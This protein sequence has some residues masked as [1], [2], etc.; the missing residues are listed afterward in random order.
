V[1]CAPVA[2]QTK[3]QDEGKVLKKQTDTVVQEGVGL[4]AFLY[5][6]FTVSPQPSSFDDRSKT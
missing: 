1:H 6:F 3:E 2:A 5:L 4:T